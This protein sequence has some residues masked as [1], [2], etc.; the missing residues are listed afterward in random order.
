MSNVTGPGRLPIKLS[1]KALSV[2]AEKFDLETINYDIIHNRL[3]IN[4][5][6]GKNKYTSD[7]QITDSTTDNI[8]KILKLYLQIFN[9]VPGGIKVQ[10]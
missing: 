7:I 4:L 3:G 5:Y 9:A 8:G 2:L 6:V 1:N 10:M